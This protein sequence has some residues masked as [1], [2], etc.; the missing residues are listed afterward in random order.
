MAG[1]GREEG[2]LGQDVGGPE[3]RGRACGRGQE[4]APLRSPGA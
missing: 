4:R 3:S 2:G 1:W